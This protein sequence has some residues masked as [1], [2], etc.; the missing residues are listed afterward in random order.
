MSRRPWEQQEERHE[1]LANGGDY[2]YAEDSVKVELSG[3]A[4]AE[5]K[6]PLHGQRRHGHV[7]RP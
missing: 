4:R 5:V 1:V 2:L 6:P 3:E 7:P